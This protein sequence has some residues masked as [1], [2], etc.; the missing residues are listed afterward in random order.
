MG[1]L[2]CCRHRNYGI[3]KDQPGLIQQNQW[4]RAGAK[5]EEEKRITLCPQGNL[6]RYHLSFGLFTLKK[7][8]LSPDLGRGAQEIILAL[9]L[10]H[11]ST[12]G[13][14]LL[15][16]GESNLFAQGGLL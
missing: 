11:P 12:S 5:E 15:L 8:R 14:C 2:D 1:V 6:A 13:L 4:C 10:K 7:I 9:V 3:R 16:C